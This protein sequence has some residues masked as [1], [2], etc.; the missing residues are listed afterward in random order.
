MALS[1]AGNCGGKSATSASRRFASGPTSNLLRLSPELFCSAA[2]SKLPERGDQPLTVHLD[3]PFSKKGTKTL[4]SRAQP[5]TRFV[6]WHKK[7]SPEESLSEQL[8]W[9]HCRCLQ[10]CAAASSIGSLVSSFNFAHGTL[11]LCVPVADLLSA[12]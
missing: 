4:L 10:G 8:L 12:S 2:L 7:L 3:V 1:G 9:L 5:L 6:L 11:G